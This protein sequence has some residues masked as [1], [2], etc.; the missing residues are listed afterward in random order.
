MRVKKDWFTIIEVLAAVTIF[1][2]LAVWIVYVNSFLI[3]QDERTS[4]VIKGNLFSKY[5]SE[6]VEEIAPPVAYSDGQEFYLTFLGDTY[7]YSLDS[8]NS[9]N[10]V[11]FFW[12]NEPNFYSHKLTYVSEVTLDWVALK[13]YKVETNYWDFSDS[14][15]VTR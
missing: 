7:S 8:Y 11:G 1:I 14:Y 4:E 13:L 3:K 12:S 15:Y 6:V 9:A 10:R 2:M 5:I